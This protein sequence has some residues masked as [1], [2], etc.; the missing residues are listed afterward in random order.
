MKTAQ[1][2]SRTL[3]AASVFTFASAASCD[4]GDIAGTGI[5]PEGETCSSETAGLEFHGAIM[6][7]EF[8]NLDAGVKVLA[9]GGTQRIAIF[10]YQTG[11]PFT[12]PF[13]PTVDAQLGSVSPAVGNQANGKGYLR[14]VDGATGTLN[15]RL[16]IAIAP[17]TGIRV[18]QTLLDSMAELPASEAAWVAPGGVMYVELTTATATAVDESMKLIG[19]GTQ[20]KWD[21]FV[22]GNP[23]PGTM[24]LLVKRGQLEQALTLKVVAGPDTIRDFSPLKS[25]VGRDTRQL[26]CFGAL[27]QNHV[28]HVPW[29]FET[30]NGTIE[31]VAADGCVMLLPATVGAL[32]FTVHAGTLSQTVTT[33]VVAQA[34]SARQESPAEFHAA[35]ARRAMVWSEARGERAILQP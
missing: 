13:E 31:P 3:F 2:I 16:Q 6:G 23:A 29:R 10:D 14:I 7:E 1:I 12:Q 24:Q 4:G 28:V 9:S 26:L 21:R 25:E 8:L 34:R 32:T 18:H 33:N 27:K 22:V 17:V 19:N 11:V 20:T 30:S 35:L 5:C 15:D